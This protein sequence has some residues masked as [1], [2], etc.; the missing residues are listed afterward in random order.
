MHSDNILNMSLNYAASLSPY[1]NKGKCGLPEKYDSIEVV[2]GNIK[3]KNNN[4]KIN[5]TYSFIFNYKI[6]EKCELL[7][8][9]IIESKLTVAITGAGISTSCGIPDFRGPNGILF[10]VIY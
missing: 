4:F 1:A 5:Q 3:Q 6:K 9:Y 7:A 2:N 10:W 8:K